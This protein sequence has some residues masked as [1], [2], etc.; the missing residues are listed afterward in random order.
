MVEELCAIVLRRVVYVD[1]SVL[2]SLVVR[3]KQPFPGIRILLA[4]RDC[5]GQGRGIT[6]CGHDVL[7]HENRCRPP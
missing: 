1:I 5:N 2:G 3:E 6:E 4:L 7:D